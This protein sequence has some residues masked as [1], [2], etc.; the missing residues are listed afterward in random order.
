MVTVILIGQFNLIFRHDADGV[1]LVGEL[2]ILI[3]IYNNNE[4]FILVIFFFPFINTIIIWG[5]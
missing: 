4:H 3:F 2:I 5:D 1:F